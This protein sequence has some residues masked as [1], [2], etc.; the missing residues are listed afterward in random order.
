MNTP[1]RTES[2]IDSPPLHSR[3]HPKGA[4]LMNRPILSP[5]KNWLPL[6]AAVLLLAAVAAVLWL[7]PPAANPDD[8]AAPEPTLSPTPALV[9]PPGT[10]PAPEFQ[11]I[12]A[13]LNSEPLSMAELRGQVVLVDIWTYS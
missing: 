7:S 10:Q 8:S 1:N 12:T 11:G 3:D 13:W 9:T 2:R 5:V 6:T 4:P